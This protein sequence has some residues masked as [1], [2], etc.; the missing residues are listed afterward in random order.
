MQTL[1]HVARLPGHDA[2]THKPV[3]RNKRL[4]RALTRVSDAPLRNGNQLTLLHNGSETYTDWLDA[5]GRAQHWVHLENYIFQDDGIGQRFAEALA[6]RA[7]AG[8]RVR[9]LYDWFGSLDVSGAF[10][11]KLRR[12]GVDVRAFN[13]LAVTSPFDVIHRDHRKLLAV[14]G[15]YASIGGVCI[16]D[17]WLDTSPVTG[18]PYRDTAVRVLGPALADIERAFADI[19]RHNGTP[20]PPDE[21]VPLNSLSAAGDVLAR[22]VVQEPE[23]MRMLRVFQVMLAAVERRVWIADAYFLAAPILREALLA[24][25]RDGIDVRILLPSTNDLPLVGAMSRYGYQPLIEAGVQIWEYA[26]LMMHAKTTVAD[27]WWSRVGST[28]LN[29]TGLQTNWE[30]DLI[31]EDQAFGAAMEKMYEH[32]LAHAREIRLSGKRRLRPRP[33]RPESRAERQAR[34]HRSDSSVKAS[35]A[36][37]RVGAAIQTAGSETLKNND[38]TISA[39]AGAALVS[40]AL[41]IARWPRLL[42]WPLALVSG[43]LGGV[44]LS[45][46]I[47]RSPN[48]ARGFTHRRAGFRPEAWRLKRRRPRGRNRRL[49]IG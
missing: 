9:V 29:I 48:V 37:A 25:A 38:R 17:P 22:V 26:G 6:E 35:L 14:D 44:S 33:I 21:L 7:A 13:P 16:A 49:D 45:R 19:W 2:A 4:D 31:A 46:A 32:D 40:L 43:L 42:A 20:L 27:G 39:V 36:M 47:A 23:R 10:W 28:N 3:L 11:R 15:T 30:I 34:R 1:D 18:L 41:L 24:A 8:V 12:S 5:I